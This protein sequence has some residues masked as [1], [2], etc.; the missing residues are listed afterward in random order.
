MAGRVGIAP[1][2]PCHHP[3]GGGR[4]MPTRS[5]VPPCAT[6]A[7]GVGKIAEGAYAAA[8]AAPP[9][10]LCHAVARISDTAPD[11]LSANGG[12]RDGDRSAARHDVWSQNDPKRKSKM[13]TLD[14]MSVVFE[15]C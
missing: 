14:E 2:S 5:Q 4:A 15:R 13:R 10:R 6:Y 9:P 11:R 7:N 12:A 3:T 8:E 1:A